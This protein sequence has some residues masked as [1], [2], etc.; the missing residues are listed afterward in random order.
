MAES[1]SPPEIDDW[2]DIEAE[3]ASAGREAC[4]WNFDGATDQI[5]RPAPAMRIG[6]EAA[7]YPRPQNH[8]LRQSRYEQQISNR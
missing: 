4:N 8:P 6:T 3:L 5:G 7:R 2:S 1:S